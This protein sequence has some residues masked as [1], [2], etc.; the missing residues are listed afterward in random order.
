MVR[1]VRAR[2]EHYF[3]DLGGLLRGREA[4][5]STLSAP[6]SPGTASERVHSAG[7]CCW[8]CCHLACVGSPPQ[9]KRFCY[10]ASASLLALY[11]AGL[12]LCYYLFTWEFRKALPWSARDVREYYETDS[13]LPDYSYQLKARITEQQFHEYIAKF[14]LTLHTPTRTYSDDTLWLSWRHVRNCDWWD[15][16]DSLE[17]TFV[18]QGNDTWIFAKYERGHL[19]VGSL[20]H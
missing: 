1:G 19:Y 3:P 12:G 2:F 17:S 6:P 5:L 4:V 15:P 13:F 10:I 8:H 14:H 16:S 18:W 9:P 11:L 7:H 20:N